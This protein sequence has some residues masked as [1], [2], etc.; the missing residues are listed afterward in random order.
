MAHCSILWQWAVVLLAS[1]GGYSGHEADAG[2]LPGRGRRGTR[3]CIDGGHL[4]DLADAV[5]PN[6]ELTS[7]AAL[8]EVAPITLAVMPY[9]RKPTLRHTCLDLSFFPDKQYDEPALAK[10]P[11]SHPLLSR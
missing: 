6:F 3:L 5:Q 1:C 2:Q 8:R 10:E 7:D 11:K 9:R 4:G